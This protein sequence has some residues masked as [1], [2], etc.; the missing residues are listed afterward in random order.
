M[1]QAKASELRDQSVPELENRLAERRRDLL[2]L[3]AQQ[4]M[5]QLDNPHR[6][7]VMHKEI[8]RILTVLNERQAKGEGGGRK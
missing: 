7:R 3:R 6:L 4:A 5:G 1:P 8:A 2:T